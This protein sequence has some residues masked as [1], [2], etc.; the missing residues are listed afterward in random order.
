M[1]RNAYGRRP[2]RGIIIPT[3]LNKVPQIVRQEWRRCPLRLH[4]LAQ[5]NEYLSIVLQ[6]VIRYFSGKNLQNKRE[7][8]RFNIIL[9]LSE[10]ETRSKGRPLERCSHT[11]KYRSIPIPADSSVVIVTVPAVVRHDRSKK[12]NIVPGPTNG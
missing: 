7:C 1:G 3:F 6:V 9:T 10:K 8:G 2:R 11:N 12:C 5:L 4:P